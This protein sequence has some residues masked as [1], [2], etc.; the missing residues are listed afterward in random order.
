MK[1]LL[2]MVLVGIMSVSMLA[3]CGKSE[4]EKLAEQLNKEY[5]EYEENREE[6]VEENASNQEFL[7]EMQAEATELKTMLEEYFSATTKDEVIS[8]A[9]EYN[10][11]YDAYMEKALDYGWTEGTARTVLVN[12]GSTTDAIP[13]NFYKGKALYIEKCENLDYEEMT[14]AYNEEGTDFVFIIKS[15]SENNNGNCFQIMK[16]DGT[17]ITPDISSITS[18]Q[19]TSVEILDVN[20]TEAIIEVID[21]ADWLYYA[22]SFD[23][24]DLTATENG[25]ENAYTKETIYSLDD[26]NRLI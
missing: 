22:L 11:M 6:K 23:T 2:M 12:M 1:K 26:L 7:A 17:I 25:L 13:E 14:F 21:N 19:T 20:G 3:G 16:N 15:N 4:E 24:S 5:E 8:I 9:K 10:D 18:E